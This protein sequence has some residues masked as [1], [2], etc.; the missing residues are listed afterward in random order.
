[1]LKD[2]SEMYV[3]LMILFVSLKAAQPRISYILKLKDYCVSLFNCNKNMGRIREVTMADAAAITAIYN[4]YITE[5]VVTFET[6]A[7]SEEEMR[8]RI[9]ELSA[10]GPYYVYEEA[11][12]VEGYCYAHLWKE[13]EAYL[14][15]YETTIYLAQGMQR[16]GIG[17]QLLTCLIAEC[18][19]RGVHALI[20]C[21]TE[22][23]AASA[24][25]HQK[26]G[27]R[28]VSQF[29]EVGYKQ[30]RWLGVTDYELRL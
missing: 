22:G 9:S 1:M 28:Q 4:K 15:T 26:L 14:H 3:R 10:R 19:K 27:F 16:K 2:G 18:R 23:N 12:R 20:A 11:G 24:A 8:K 17:T 21:L 7:L 13:R 25:L 6:A 5:S 29:S 30:G